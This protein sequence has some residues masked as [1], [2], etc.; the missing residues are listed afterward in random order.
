MPSKTRFIAAAALAT[1]MALP[2]G[3][4]AADHTVS[5]AVTNAS[6]SL[7]VGTSPAAMT[8]SPNS[9]GSGVAGT[10]AVTSTN[11]WWLWA[12]D[13]GAGGNGKMDL[14]V[15]GPCDA[16][17]SAAELASNLKVNTSGTVGTLGSLTTSN[18]YQNLTGAFASVASGNLTQVLTTGYQQP[19]GNES[20]KGGCAYTE[21]VT[22][23]VS[24]DASGTSIVP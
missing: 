1:A 10:L 12:K 24:T 23:G 17:S 13:G 7:A 19:V 6:L 9:T 21:T 20:L 15:A 8:L 22:Y 16:T 14:V 3:A 2:A 18:T 4:Q 11:P 5:A